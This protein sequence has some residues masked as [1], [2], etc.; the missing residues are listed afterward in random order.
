MQIENYKYIEEKQKVINSI[1]H[2]I[3][4]HLIVISSL[5]NEKKYDELED[6]LKGIYEKTTKGLFMQ[7]QVIL[8][9]ILLS[10]KNASKLQAKELKLKFI[11]TLRKN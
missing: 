9:L 4:N 8:L 6:Y 5:C 10:M 1:K 2:D 3:N 11:L 7:E